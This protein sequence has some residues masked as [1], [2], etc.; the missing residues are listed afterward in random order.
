MAAKAL[1]FVAVCATCAG[2]AGLRLSDTRIDPASP[3]AGDVAKL[4]RA[5]PDYPEFSEIPPIP[6]DVRPV[7]L[8]GAAAADLLELRD[9]ILRATAPDTWTLKGGEATDAFADRAR[10]AAGPEFTPG[11]PS[12]TEAFARALR[13]RATPP[14]PPRR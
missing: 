5:N 11:D 14:P 1:A 8:Y 13:K 4:A 6:T 12:A 2:C 3:V 10:A 7:R 9:R